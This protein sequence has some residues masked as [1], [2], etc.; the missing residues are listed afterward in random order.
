MVDN[1]GERKVNALQ[2]APIVGSSLCMGLGLVGL[3]RPSVFMR[4]C[5][6]KPSGPA[7]T[8]EIR[9]IFGGCL[10]ALGAVTLATASA[11]VYLT[12]A[13]LWFSS[14]IVKIVFMLIDKATFISLIP[15]LAGDIPLGLLMLA[16]WFA[17][18]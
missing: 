7:G 6:L 4:M 18:K 16:G 14:A 17:E 9:A 5:S 3:F 15:G 1:P 13:I 11:L 10:I 8:L 12:A 2:V